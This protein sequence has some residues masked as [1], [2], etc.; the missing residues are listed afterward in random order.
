MIVR[1]GDFKFKFKNLKELEHVLTTKTKTLLPS[2]G[3]IKKTEKRVRFAWNYLSL[4]RHHDQFL[5]DF[6]DEIKD[7]FLEQQRQLEINEKTIL[8][9]YVQHMNQIVNDVFFQN[10]KKKISEELVPKNVAKLCELQWT[11]LPTTRSL[12]VMSSTSSSSTASRTLSALKQH[13]KSTW[14]DWSVR[15]CCVD[16]TMAYLHLFEKMQKHIRVFCNQFKRVKT[17]FVHDL[18]LEL[19]NYDKIIRDHT[20]KHR[21]EVIEM[22]K[23]L[24]HNLKP[25][26]DLWKQKKI[27]DDEYYKTKVIYESQF[28]KHKTKLEHQFSDFFK[29]QHETLIERVNNCHATQ[30]LRLQNK[31]E[32]FIKN[33][34]DT[35]Q[36]FQIYYMEFLK[37]NAK[38]NKITEDIH[39]TILEILKSELESFS[40]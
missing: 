23:I 40:C 37:I 32:L 1:E 5:V 18:E 27:L 25:L 6:I 10:A 4:V 14:K 8:Q 16:Q 21:N 33:F 3:S 39:K 29:R 19:A 17:S 35:K 20:L 30:W 15:H 22:C 12:T 38:E 9:D 24:C 34:E 2:S 26:S 13:L 28:Q 7:Q 11:T 31:H 36:Q